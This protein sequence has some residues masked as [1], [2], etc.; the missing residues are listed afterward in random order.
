MFLLLFYVFVTTILPTEKLQRHTQEH[1]L[2]HMLHQNVDVHQPILK[3][4][5]VYLEE[6]V[7]KMETR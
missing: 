4:Q 6:S 2:Q 1:F 7:L 5:L 3:S